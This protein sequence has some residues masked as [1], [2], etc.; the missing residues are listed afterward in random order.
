MA[1]TSAIAYVVNHLHTCVCKNITGQT[2]ANTS[3]VLEIVKYNIFLRPE[4][5]CCCHGKSLCPANKTYV[6]E[7]K[8]NQETRGVHECSS[9]NDT[10]EHS[11][12]TRM[13]L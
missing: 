9:P 6:F 4:E 5:A 8:L 7:N 1:I 11:Q 10:R 12:T 2:N 13:C 3:K